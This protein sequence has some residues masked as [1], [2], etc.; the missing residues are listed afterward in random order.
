MSQATG[1]L[2]RKKMVRIPTMTVAGVATGLAAATVLPAVP[3]NAT[4]AYE[5][6]VI[7]SPRIPSGL[8]MQVCGHNQYGSGKCRYASDVGYT[9]PLGESTM[10]MTQNWWWISNITLWWD[11]HHSKSNAGCNVQD[12]SHSGN[13]AIVYAQFSHHNC[14]QP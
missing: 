12:V 5:V 14:A 1:Q 7:A 6:I 4:R 13:Y 8:G 9:G 2:M 11:N 3:A 10:W